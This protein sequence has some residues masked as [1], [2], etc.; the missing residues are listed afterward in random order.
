MVAQHGH[1]VAHSIDWKCKRSF[2]HQKIATKAAKNGTK[3]L[4]LLIIK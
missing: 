3:F 2:G 4:T 1:H